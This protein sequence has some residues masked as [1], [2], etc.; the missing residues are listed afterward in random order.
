MLEKITCYPAGVTDMEALVD[1]ATYDGMKELLEDEF[2]SF[3]EM[4]FS[5]NQE[6]LDKI[7][8]GLESNDAPAIQAAAHTLKSSSG[9]IGAIK[10][11][12]LAQ[13]IETQASIGSTESISMIFTESQELFDT[14]KANLS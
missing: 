8:G 12:T 2:P 6:A 10:L 5:E 7:K 14:L 13:D 9:Y 3:L 1:T 11:A 4:F